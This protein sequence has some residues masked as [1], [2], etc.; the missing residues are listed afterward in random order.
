MSIIPNWEA[1]LPK[2]EAGEQGHVD[3]SEFDSMV[4]GGMYSAA[5][6][7]VQRIAGIES[8]KVRAI[9]DERDSAKR[10][11]MLRDFMGIGPEVDFYWVMPFFAEYV[12]AVH[13]RA[14]RTDEEGGGTNEHGSFTEITRNANVSPLPSGLLFGQGFNLHIGTGSGVGPGACV[15]NVSPGQ[16]FLSRGADS[17]PFTHSFKP[18]RRS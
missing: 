7:Y 1:K 9:N 16:Y 2:L 11:K 14:C 4:R 17:R 13:L 12:R 10:D 18:N 5:D 15:L 3:T 6:P 8:A